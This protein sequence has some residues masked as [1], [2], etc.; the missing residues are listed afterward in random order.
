MSEFQELIKNF[1]RIRYYMRQFFVYGYKSRS[2]YEGKS[3]RTY[4]NERRRIESW[5]SGCIQSGYTQKEK[6][7]YISVDSKTIPQNPLYAAWK[8]KS[9]TDNDILLHFFL[10]DLL[11]EHPEGMTSGELCD[12]MSA[13]YGMVFDSQTVRLKLKE[14]ERLGF[15]E[16][17]KQGKRL[18]Y[19][20]L[21]GPIQP[22]PQTILPALRPDSDLPGTDGASARYASLQQ[23]T[24]QSL[25]TAVTYFQEAAPFGFIGSTILDHENQENQWFSFKHHFLVH[26]LEDG[27][28]ANVLAA[29]KEHRSIAFENKSSRS[30]ATTSMRGL[31]LKIFVSTQTGRRYLCLYLEERRRF[32]NVRLD[33]MTKVVP[34]DICSSYEHRQQLLSK[35]LASCWGVSFGGS[36]RMEEIHIKFFLDEDKEAHILNRLYREGR[37][38]ELLKIRDHEYLYSGAF[39]DT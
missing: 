28:L 33:A 25:L 22:H 2:D 13:E 16:S 12:A 10:P 39:F 32:T 31:P 36:S 30:R 34:L 21:P 3:A 8:S 14:Y 37:G 18:C 24:W 35:N 11:W 15:L 26:T 20:L 6:H 5:L 1:H 19:R 7:V 4:D 29:M 38:G 23:Q 9:F 27:V 17:Q